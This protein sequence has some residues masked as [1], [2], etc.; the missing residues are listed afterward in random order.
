MAIVYFDSYVRRDGR[1]Y[2]ERRQEKHWY[3]ADMLERPA[4]P[5]QLW[6]KFAHLTPHLPAD[7]PTWQSFWDS[8]EPDAL[9]ALT[10][11]P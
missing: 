1:W 2:F 4:P 10:R 7:F 11:Q 8:M 6:E 5:F 3:S 9:N